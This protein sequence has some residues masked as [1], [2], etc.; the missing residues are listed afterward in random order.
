MSIYLQIYSKH[1][2]SLI[3]SKYGC[4]NAYPAVILYKGLNF[5]IFY[6]RSMNKGLTWTENILF[7]PFGYISGILGILSTMKEIFL[8]SGSP[9]TFIILTN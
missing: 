6:K 5:S 8:H 9:M 7:K 1:L 2:W 3:S 4:A